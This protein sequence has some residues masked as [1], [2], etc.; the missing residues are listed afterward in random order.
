MYIF[1]STY[2]FILN[3]KDPTYYSFQQ[4]YAENANGIQ[5]ECMNIHCTILVM[6]LKV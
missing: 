3:D 4:V 5:I 1:D 2:K 6:K